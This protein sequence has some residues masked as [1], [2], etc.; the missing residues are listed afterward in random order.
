MLSVNEAR[1]RLLENFHPLDPE[2]LAI[3]QAAGRVLAVDIT[4]TQDLPPFANSSMD[5]YAV[6]CRDVATAS[7]EHPA[8]LKVSGDIPAGSGQP[9]P[10]VDGTAARIMTGAPV[11][12]GAEAVVPVEDTDDPRDQAHTAPMPEFIRI[13]QSAPLGANVRPVGQDVRAG[14]IVL[15]AGMVLQPAAIGVLAA[16]GSARVEVYRRPLIAIFSTGDEL[17]E[18]GESLGPGQIRDTNSYA[19]A[20][21]IERYGG[22]V[23]RLGIARDRVDQVQAKLQAAGEAGADLILSSAGVSVGA[24]D[25]VKAAVGAEGKLDFWRVRMRP[26]KPLAFGNVRGIP[27]V[28]LPGNPVSAL[29]CF[30]V[31]VRPA[32]LKMGGRR[33]WEKP[34]LP[35]TLLEPMHSD[36]RESYLRVIIERRG[37]GYVARST[38]DQG[39]AVLTSL[40][41]ANGLLI[42]PE[43]VTEA[44]A[45]S[46]LS[47]WALEAW[48]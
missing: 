31:F 36:G 16:L 35:V 21:A 28:G 3:D 47:A 48:D 14:Q 46:V 8:A 22:R 32:L 24:Y 27:F 7:R 42:I 41:Q 37:E 17:R 5:G 11:P 13:F 26:G 38:G 18:V 45:G 9:L 44:P 15:R 1:A 10:L 39:S 12:D 4:A 19:V 6:R 25:V 34:A 30:E 33:R 29:V 20:A 2:T 43:N 23:L 40:V